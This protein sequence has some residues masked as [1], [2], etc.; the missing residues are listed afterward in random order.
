MIR[1]VEVFMVV[2]NFMCDPLHDY[3]TLKKFVYM[4]NLKK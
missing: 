1:S 3:L 4:V 2:Y